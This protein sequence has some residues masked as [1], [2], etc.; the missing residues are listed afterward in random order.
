MHPDFGITRFN[1]FGMTD[2]F[3]ILL[4]IVFLYKIFSCSSD[5]DGGK[6]LNAVTCVGIINNNAGIIHALSL[7]SKPENSLSWQPWMEN[8]QQNPA[9]Y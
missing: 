6:K 5:P 7:E 4:W 9:A 2:V 3:I 1:K 8:W